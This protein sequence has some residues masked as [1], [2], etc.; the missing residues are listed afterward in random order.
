MN[1]NLVHLTNSSNGFNIVYD[2]ISS[3][4]ATHF[5]DK[6]D[7]REIAE[8][9]LSIIEIDGDIVAT[10]IDFGKPVGLNDVVEVNHDDK[11]YY[12]IRILR[13]D[14]GYVQFTTSKDRQYSNF[15]SVHLEKRSESVYELM[16]CWIGRYE[17]PPFP[18]MKNANTESKEYWGKH[19]F[20]EGS[21]EII[22]GSR[23]ENCPW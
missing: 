6:S 8:K 20:V 23:I 15:L 16:S 7:L 4:T 18:L 3:H 19:A 10:D 5:K 12:A 9:A 13:E 2:P 21:Q 11:V 14:Q 22:P 17:S 1:S